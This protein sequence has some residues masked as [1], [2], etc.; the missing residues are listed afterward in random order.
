MQYYPRMSYVPALRARG[1]LWLSAVVVLVGGC[2][3][4]VGDL[5]DP[6]DLSGS[7][8][9]VSSGGKTGKAGSGGNGGGGTT[10]G[11]GGIAPES[12]GGPGSGGAGGVGSGGLSVGGTSVDPPDG[13]DGGDG[14]VGDGG[15]ANG[16]GGTASGGTGGAVSSG[17]VSGSGG[18]AATG[19]SVTASGGTGGASGGTGG[20]SGGTGGKG[21]GGSV[22]C[23]IDVDQ[24]GYISKACGGPDCDDSD[25]F[26]RPNQTAYFDKASKGG[27]F[28]YNCNNS[29]ELDPALNRKNNCGL[30]GSGCN[31]P[32]AYL[33]GTGP[34][35]ACGNAAPWGTCKDEVLGLSCSNSPRVNMTMACK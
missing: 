24:D 35:P 2:Q 29:I 1:P 5:P 3:A 30:L 23:T 10:D 6:A 8:G 7:G 19:G 18:A 4:L 32:E 31:R 34:V 33:V 9:G 21:T 28:D 17:G 22:T 15:N 13:G 12:G 27:I 26:V 14:S 20:A 25:E 16:S 11:G